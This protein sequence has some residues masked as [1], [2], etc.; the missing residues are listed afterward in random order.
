M[1][2]QRAPCKCLPTW[3]RQ[4]RKLP[5]NPDC[6]H[7]SLPFG[8][9]EFMFVCYWLCPCGNGKTT[10]HCVAVPLHDQCTVNYQKHMTDNGYDRFVDRCFVGL[11]KMSMKMA[12]EM[13]DACRENHHPLQSKCANCRVVQQKETKFFK[14]SCKEIHYCCKACQ[15]ADWKRHKQTCTFEKCETL[16]SPVEEM[17]I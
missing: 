11:D 13:V 17:K 10:V 5:D 12:Q 3:L 4:Q 6:S 2:K 7:C 16:V 15:V 1:I 9:N 8:K 14:C